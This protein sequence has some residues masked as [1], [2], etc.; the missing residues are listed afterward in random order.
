[1]TR[2]S[3]PGSRLRLE[4]LEEREVPAILFGVTTANQLVTFD[5]A[6]PSVLLRAV[7]ITGMINAGEVIT[8]IDVRPTTGGLYGH[9]NFDRLYLIFPSSGFA[10]PIGGPVPVTAANIGMDFNPV[11][12]RLRILSNLGENILLNPNNGTLAL[13]AS[14][15]AYRPGD[16][17]F[18]VPPRITG[19]ANTNN[20]LGARTTSIFGIDHVENTLVRLGVTTPND[21]F[22][23]TVGFLNVPMSPRPGFDI[24]PVTDTAFLTT[25]LPGQFVTQLFTVNLTTGAATLVGT[26]GGNVILSGIA[27]DA[28]GT[29]GF[30]SAAGFA[31][32]P[33]A[34]P[35]FFFN[36]ATGTFTPMFPTLTQPFPPGTFSPLFPSLVQPFAP[37]TFSP[38]FATNVTPLFGTTFSSSTSTFNSQAPLFS[39]TGPTVF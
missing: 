12:D 4:P 9:S 17:L 10:L 31:A 3:R 11:N 26:V 21:G 39:T 24:A 5:S 34:P 37:G 15:L 25:Q 32:L 13:T 28:R 23:T 33:P 20:V 36:P 1:M 19:L 8:D 30:V 14:P 29:S 38:L 6:N 16:P 22:L 27:V 18:G 7:Q 2:D 35:G